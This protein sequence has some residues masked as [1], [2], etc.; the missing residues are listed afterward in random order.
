MQRLDVAV[1]PRPGSE[2]PWETRKTGSAAIECAM[3]AAG[4]LS[5]ARFENVNLWDVAGG[6]AL[7]LAAGGTVHIREDGGWKAL[8]R[9]ENGADLH[10]WKRPMIV[11]EPEAAGA[12]VRA[13]A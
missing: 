6:A 5:V 2:G 4:P 10:R 1:V 8:E 11:G 13:A 7:V 12:M 3:V 9:F